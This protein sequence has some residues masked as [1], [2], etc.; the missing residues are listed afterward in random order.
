LAFSSANAKL[1]QELFDF[2]VHLLLS[3]GKRIKPNSCQLDFYYLSQ[4]NNFSRKSDFKTKTFENE[5][6]GKE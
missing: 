5:V 2:P 1:F 4:N 3:F 6:N